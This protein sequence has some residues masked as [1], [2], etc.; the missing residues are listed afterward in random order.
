MPLYTNRV[1]DEYGNTWHPPVIIEAE[2]EQ[3]DLMPEITMLRVSAPA[4]FDWPRVYASQFQEVPATAGPPRLL[5][6][7][8]WTALVG[9]E[10]GS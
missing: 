8:E 3:H 9:W 5:E 4:E 2:P 6:R 10:D 7:E 1:A